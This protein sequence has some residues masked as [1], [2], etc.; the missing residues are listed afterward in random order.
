MGLTGAT[1]SFFLGFGAGVLI[2]LSGSFARA[3]CASPTGVDGQLLYNAGVLQ[4]CASTVW[5]TVIDTDLGT[6]CS[7]AGTIK[8][9]SSE[10]VYCS[11]GLTWQRTAPLNDPWGG[12]WGACTAGQAG[13]FYYDSVGTYYWF[14]TGSH[15]SRMGP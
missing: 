7:P 6:A 9:V 4:Y 15:W 10:I 14:C 3:A 12:T 11:S 13:Y 1:R 8:F 5:R 2:L